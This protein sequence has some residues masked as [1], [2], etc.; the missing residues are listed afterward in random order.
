MKRCGDCENCKKVEVMKLRCLGALD[1]IRVGQNP[2]HGSL[3][4]QFPTTTIITSDD[5]AGIWNDCLRD[6]PCTKEEA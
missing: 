5:V 1:S 2:P 4:C 6:W 3:S